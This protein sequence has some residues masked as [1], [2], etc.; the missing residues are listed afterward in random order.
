MPI[1]KANV[2]EFISR[3]PDQTRRIGMRLG[4]LIQ[5]GDIICLSGDLGAGKTTLV[6]GIARGWGSTDSA[7][8]PTF[9]LVNTYRRLDGNVLNHLDAYRLQDAFE[10]EALDLDNLVE[11]GVLVVEWPERILAALPEDNLWIAMDWVAD[12]H[13][14]MLFTPHGDSYAKKLEQLKASTVKGFE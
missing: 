4:D 1:L 10:A 12:E 11:G 14:R 7:T 3:S 9:V 8:S 6:Q 13:R 5:S 2:F